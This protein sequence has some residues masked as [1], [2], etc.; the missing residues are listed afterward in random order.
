MLN[1]DS[2]D[3]SAGALNPLAALN[4]LRDPFDGFDLH[5][6]ASIGNKELSATTD[7]TCVAGVGFRNKLRKTGFEPGQLNLDGDNP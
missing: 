3:A 7:N 6:N 5:E 4:R 1:P 2:S